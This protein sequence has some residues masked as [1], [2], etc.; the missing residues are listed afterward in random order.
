MMFHLPSFLVGCGVGFAT[1]SLSEH[2]RPV[3]REIATAGYRLAGALTTRAARA[4]EDF[5]DLLAE[6]RARAAGKAIVAEQP[7]SH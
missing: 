6:A 1:R 5:E 7:P 2:F 3:V 4:R